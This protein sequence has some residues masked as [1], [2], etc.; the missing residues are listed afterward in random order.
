ME[1]VIFPREYVLRQ[2]EV[3]KKRRIVRQAERFAD[4]VEKM[5]GEK[6]PQNDRGTVK[7]AAGMRGTN[8]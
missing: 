4:A 1:K 2:R 7:P 3:L 5:L 6:A 8:K